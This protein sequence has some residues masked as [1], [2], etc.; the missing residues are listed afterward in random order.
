[1]RDTEEGLVSP[2]ASIFP[3]RKDYSCH[4]LNLQDLAFRVNRKYSQVF[5][6]IHILTLE[7]IS[8]VLLFLR[9]T[10]GR[11]RLSKK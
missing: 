8:G 7:E 11:K 9:G 2:H 4:K 3:A 5:D 1:M 6:F 10:D